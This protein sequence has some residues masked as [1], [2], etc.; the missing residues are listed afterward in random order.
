[1]DINYDGNDI[2]NGHQKKTDSAKD[3]QQL[4]QKDNACVSFTWINKN[5][6]D[7]G[8]IGREGECSIKHTKANRTPLKHVVS[9][10]KHCGNI[11]LML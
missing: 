2:N 8:L 11:S 3:C 6:P 5:V 1:M 10:P 4:C 9:G 7:G